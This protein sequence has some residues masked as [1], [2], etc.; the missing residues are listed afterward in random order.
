MSLRTGYGATKAMEAY[1]SIA[2]RGIR[3]RF[4]QGPGNRG[5]FLGIQRPQQGLNEGFRP[6]G[7]QEPG[8]LL[9]LPGLARTPEQDDLPGTYLFI[10][11]LLPVTLLQAR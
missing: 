8:R 11:S 4:G 3:H 1:G 6:P 10:A 2:G 5:K 9:P 7:D